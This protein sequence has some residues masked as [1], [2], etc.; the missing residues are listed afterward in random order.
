MM[1]DAITTSSA[2]EADNAVAAL[3]FDGKSSRQYHVHFRVVGQTASVTGE[4]SRQCFLQDLRISERFRRAS[5]KITFIDGA[6]LEVRDVQA[7][8]TLLQATGYSESRVVK[9]QHRWRTVMAALTSIVALLVLAYFYLLPALSKTIVN[10]LPPF[11]EHGL[12]EQTLAMLEGP[13][14]QPSGLSLATQAAL[15]ERFSNLV[16]PDGPPP[17]YKI[18]FRKSAMGPNAFAL[19]SGEIVVTDSLV[20]LLDDDDALMGVLAHELGHLHERHMMRRLIQGSVIGAVATVLV[21]DFSVLA[22]NASTVMLDMH[23]S[24]DAEREADDYA[25]AL[26]RAN[27]IP[28]SKLTLVFEKLGEA[29]GA[30][31]PYLSSHPGGAERIARIRRP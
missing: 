20:L 30:S 12:G 26:F 6:Y 4:F 17:V 13:I 15:A 24:R 22:A 10:H 19:P 21:G 1:D 31:A 18:L 5:R 16:T 2:R 29:T 3:Y 25:V 27:G 7:L 23:Y 14:L 9:A 28:L 11:I 8:N